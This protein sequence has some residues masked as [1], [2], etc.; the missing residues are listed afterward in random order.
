MAIHVC[1]II[2]RNYLASARVLFESFI[3]SNPGGTLSVLIVDDRY[4]T[5][6][7][8]SESFEVLQIDEV[9]IEPSEVL[10]MAA[11]YNVT[12]FAT[13]VKPWLLQTLVERWNEPVIYLDPDIMVFRPL[14]AIYQLATEHEIVV[15]P[16]AT[17]PI[18][19]DEKNVSE[20]E[21]LAVGIYN[22]GF[23]CIGV[24]GMKFLQFWK[25]RLKRE[26]ISEPKNM[27]FVDQRW[28]D[29]APAMFD[30]FIL[31]APTFNVAYWNL[32]YRNVEFDRASD[33]YLVNGQ[34]IH[35]FHFSGY[36]PK[37]PELLSKYQGGKARVLFSTEPDLKQLCDLYGS[38]LMANGYKASASVG[39]AYV[40]LDN[41]MLY[42]HF[43]R[44]AYRQA[45][46]S[47]EKTDSSAPPNP[48][49]GSAAFLTWL[50]FPNEGENI[51]RYLSQVYT[52]RKDL[53]L[54]IPDAG[55]RIGD[56]LDWCWGEA[57]KG[58]FDPRLIPAG[59]SDLEN[60]DM[61][62]ALENEHDVSPDG[63]Q[64]AGYFKA[65]MGVGEL[66]RNTV[67]AVQATGI[68]YSTLTDTDVIH[69]Q[70]LDFNESVGGAHSVNIVCVNA[71]SLE[72]FAF[73]MGHEYF[74]DRYTIGVWAWELEEFPAEFDPSFELV[75]EVWGCSKF[76]RDAIASRGMKDV[77]ALPIT[78]VPPK[79]VHDFDVTSLGIPTGYMFLFCFDLLSVFER[80]NPFG[81]IDAFTSAFKDGEGPVLVI[82]ALNGDKRLAEIERIRMKI[83]GRSDIFIIDKYLDYED[84]IGLFSAA[85]CYVS[86]HRSEGLGLTIA[87]AM[88]LGKP[89]I[90]TAYSGNMDFMNSENSYLIPF[91]YIEVPEGCDPYRPGARW[92]DPDIA[93]ASEAMR[94]VYENQ[95]EALR[96]GECARK[97]ILNEHAPQVASSFI[98]ERYGYALRKLDG[99]SE[100]SADDVPRE[101]RNQEGRRDATSKSS[102]MST[103]TK[104]DVPPLIAMALR[105]A[106]YDGVTRLPRLSRIVRR[107]LKKLLLV[108][109]NQQ[110]ELNTSLAM[111]TEHLAR[112]WNE[113]QV[114]L[115]QL[116][117]NLRR[118][119][120]KFQAEQLR[121]QDF[122]LKFETLHRNL[123]EM[124]VRISELERNDSG[125]HH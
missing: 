95:E 3:E 96:I 23:I 54:H 41:G 79:V 47:A 71:D 83:Q 20:S 52:T 44:S 15:T 46:L 109:D 30:T 42:D 26:C 72:H 117:V 115:D 66:G 116:Q 38:R 56:L 2:A 55:N 76:T 11:L 81:L 43:M 87:E 78:I 14:D 8:D 84:N 125:V 37:V 114:R 65:E 19:R 57:A 35:F 6:G 31:K 39:Y 13:A 107:I 67:K 112:L 74:R 85:D 104:A 17:M 80:K 105:S 50:N 111:G 64:V 103:G 82:K 108:R 40:T 122:E 94:F 61:R 70:D 98:T 93:K 68:P 5:V 101:S 90:A 1:T 99:L 49:S 77:Y 89:V 60:I 28:V 16:H 34:P 12:E 25:E 10:I 27:R 63:I 73:R 59:T 22:L 100:E 21:I 88:S 4:K 110:Q 123:V 106:E 48:F 9:G 62:V 121:S 29:F 36:N 7:K 51:S 86:L 33:R 69:R 113:M 75:D 18:P 120:L 45:L 91:K 119:D 97:Y 53:R 32:H 118:G 92:A 24:T 124:D 102:I 58:K